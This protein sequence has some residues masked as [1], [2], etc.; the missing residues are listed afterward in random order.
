MVGVLASSFLGILVRSYS[1][2]LQH[3]QAP[4]AYLHINAMPSVRKRL[5]MALGLKG[6]ESSSPVKASSMDMNRR[7]IDSGYH[8]MIAKPNRES[9]NSLCE[10]TTFISPDPSPG[11]LRKAISTTFSGAMQTLSNTVRSTTSY[12]YPTPGET[13]LPSSEWAECETPKKESPR[14]SIMSSF[15]SRR[16]RSTPR[17]SDAKTESPE[18]LQSTVPVTQEEAPALDVDIP[19]P[20]FNYE[21]LERASVTLGSQLLAGVKLPVGSKNLWPGPTR[22][23]VRQV[24]D[25]DR[26]GISYHVATDPDDPY[27]EKGDEC[28]YGL[29][30]IN[31]P[32][33]LSVSASSESF[34]CRRSDDKGY[35]TGQ[36]SDTDVSAPSPITASE[37]WAL[38]ASKLETLDGT[39]EQKASPESLSRKCEPQ[40]TCLKDSVSASSSLSEAT[41]TSKSRTLDTRTT[42]ATYDSDAESLDSSMGSR[43]T[44]ERHRADRERRYIKIVDMFPD[45]E[46]DDETEPELHLERSP[47]KRL[48]YYAEE[49]VQ[50]RVKTRRCKSTP[51]FP[52]GDLRYAVE[53]IERPAFPV[54]D[55]ACAVAATDTPPVMTSEP[56]ETL[57]QQRPLL[58]QIDTVDQ[59]QRLRDPDALNL[60]VSRGELPWSPLAVL[61]PSRV[62][63]PSSPENSPFNAPATPKTAL[64][65]R[66]LTGIEPSNYG[67]GSLDV[68]CS[69][70]S[71]GSMGVSANSSCEQ[72]SKT[73]PHN[74]EDAIL[75]TEEIPGSTCVSS[76]SKTN[77]VGEDA[78]QAGS[79]A[80]GISMPIRLLDVIQKQSMV[81]NFDERELE[82]PS[83]FTPTS[84]GM[85][86]STN[87]AQSEARYTLPKQ[88][89]SSN[90]ALM[91]SRMAST[92]SNSPDDSCVITTHSPSCNYPP[93]FPSLDV[94]SKPARK[95]SNAYSAAIQGEDQIRVTEP[96]QA[97]ID[98]WLSSPFDS[99]NNQSEPTSTPVSAKSSR[100]ADLIQNNSKASS[101]KQRNLPSPST[102]TKSSLQ[103][104][105]NSNDIRQTFNSARLPSFGSPSPIASKKERRKQRKSLQLRRRNQLGTDE[106]SL[107]D[108]W[109]DPIEKA[110]LSKE[111]PGG[112]GQAGKSSSQRK[113]PRV[114]STTWSVDKNEN[115][116]SEY[117]YENP[118]GEAFPRSINRRLGNTSYPGYELD[119]AF[120]TSS[121]ESSCPDSD[122]DL[123]QNCDD[124]VVY[125][126]SSNAIYSHSSPKRNSKSPRDKV[127][128]LAVQR[129]LERKSDRASQRLVGKLKSGTFVDDDVHGSDPARKDGRPPWRP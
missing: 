22:L 52:T 123:R 39:V 73:A 122:W 36:E 116:E 20:S 13:D 50:G 9:Q 60:P 6:K 90:T 92:L 17:M 95:I 61:S 110:K 15:R 24:S 18:R 62:K 101:L 7:S 89:S 16:Q 99:P 25:D 103:S 87:R 33:G 100:C 49:L 28:Q 66:K 81:D 97:S 54:G 3:L 76:P 55:I 35:V 118:I 5:S 69:G 71:L 109:L 31:S 86:C 82:N 67:A 96:T 27:V 12:I 56:L 112:K 75:K 129:E 117:D 125:S 124:K 65:S 114:R 29:S 77:H 108:Q 105:G 107:E 57:L 120:R 63:L 80:P 8:S 2:R 119:S 127:E 84:K 32:S 83:I 37:L 85:K 14:P 106:A 115:G 10:E 121:S 53:A 1:I 11:K 98:L 68:H 51:K 47:S 102:G 19:N 46:S 4:S 26:E 21:S 41:R 43:A 128:K 59:T 70:S 44:W 42:S 48:V 93:P 58:G 23:T 94:R 78:Y 79:R 45:T 30:F 40:K 113:G 72:Q 64:M 74:A 111:S 34:K 104:P 126:A 91:H 88:R 38:A